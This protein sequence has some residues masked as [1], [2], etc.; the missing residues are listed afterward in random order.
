VEDKATK[1]SY[2]RLDVLAAL[3]HVFAHAKKN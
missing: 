3:D 1:R 2:R